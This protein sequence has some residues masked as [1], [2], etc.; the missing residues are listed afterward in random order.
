MMKKKEVD[1]KT[2]PTKPETTNLL[3]SCVWVIH[4]LPTTWSATSRSAGKYDAGQG[5]NVPVQIHQ[6]GVHAKASS[7]V[8]SAE[9]KQQ[10]SNNIV[11]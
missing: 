11:A 5:D 4:T 8:A 1:R 3:D 7:D 2:R 10:Y 9:S 6:H